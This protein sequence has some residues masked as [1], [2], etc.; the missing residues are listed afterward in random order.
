MFAPGAGLSRSSRRHGRGKRA[1]IR[2]PEDAMHQYHQQIKAL[3][4][5]R[6]GNRGEAMLM[7]HKARYV[8]VRPYRLATRP[9]DEFLSGPALD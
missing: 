4:V 2:E 7:R 1:T 3:G 6:V 9:E 8:T 5:E